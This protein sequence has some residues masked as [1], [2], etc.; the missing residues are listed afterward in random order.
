MIWFETTFTLISND[1]IRL[2][3]YFLFST[4]QFG[5]L[6]KCG[7]NHFPGERKISHNTSKFKAACLEIF[8]ISLNSRLQKSSVRL[9]TCISYTV[10]NQKLFFKCW[11]ILLKIFWQN[12]S[13]SEST[14]IA[15]AIIGSPK[16]APKRCSAHFMTYGTMA[17]IPSSNKW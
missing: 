9:C 16:K 12:P 17:I 10:N 13:A 11:F 4:D 6:N 1:T 5:S 15:D 2:K 14:T 8:L 7:R 3:C